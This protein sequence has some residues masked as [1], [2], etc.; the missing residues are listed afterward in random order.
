MI[1]KKNAKIICIPSGG[2]GNQYFQFLYSKNIS[3]KNNI[4]LEFNE[5]LINLDFKYKTKFFLEIKKK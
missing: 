5:T 4:S 2:L 3:L 1:N